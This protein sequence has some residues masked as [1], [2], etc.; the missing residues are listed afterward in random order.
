MDGEDKAERL[1]V[2]RVVTKSVASSS[3]ERMVATMFRV[4]MRR[5]CGRGVSEVRV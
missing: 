5:V 4:K 1:S 2:L 3:K